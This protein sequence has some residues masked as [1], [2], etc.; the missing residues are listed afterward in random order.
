MK[1]LLK[2][3][4]AAAANRVEEWKNCKLEYRPAGNGITNPN[5]IVTADDKNYFLK[6]PGA[7][8][9]SFI[10]RDNC[11]EANLI[12]MKSGSGPGVFRYFPDTG[13]EIWEWLEGYRQ[14]TFGDIYTREIFTKIAETTLK[15]HSY[16]EKPLPL[17]QSLFEQARHMIRRADKLGYKP[18][19]YDRIIFLLDTIED[20][21]KA[22]GINLC[23]SHN[24]L[25]T[26]NFM[27]NPETGI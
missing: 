3:D 24:D 6:I 16:R 23:P 22:D 7:G 8:T 2:T 26:N 21:V 15:F 17:T 19:W 12:A 14:L 11:H 5:F 20:A 10:D 4:I 1:K 9:D 25:W 27:Y 13:V 18:P